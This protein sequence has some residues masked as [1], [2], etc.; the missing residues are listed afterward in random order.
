M[1]WY[2]TWLESRLRFFVTA[3]VLVFVV[4]WAILNCDHAMARF[5]RKPPITFA[6]YVWH[7]YAGQFQAVWVA[8]VLFLGLGGLL[9]ERALGTT[10][11]TL[12]MPVSR[13][14]W[15]AARAT[16]GIVESAVLAA[17]PVIVIPLTA[18]FVGR[19]YPVWEALKY[20]TLLFAMGIVFFCV[21]LL[22]SSILPGEFAA[23][24]VGL[25][26][27]YFVFTAYDYLYRWFPYFNMNALLSGADFVDRSSGFLHGWPWPATLT[28]LAVAASL[29][30]GATRVTE[31]LD[32]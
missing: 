14:R 3:L 4:S 26:S 21:G 5:D 8:S 12:S 32:F 2:K 11:Y 22:Y 18:S 28:C 19:S 30:I 31:H 1:I 20:S 15:M 29:Y 16:V 25:V 9:R 27:L 7:V 17:I 24:A 10:Q 23:A 6:Q 13:M